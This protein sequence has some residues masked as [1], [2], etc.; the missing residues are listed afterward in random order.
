MVSRR[1]TV[2]ELRVLVT[3][4]DRVA[5]ILLGGALALQGQV[6]VSDTLGKPLHVAVEIPTKNH[7]LWPGVLTLASNE[8]RFESDRHGSDELLFS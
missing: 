7:Q 5:A 8:V 3:T 6:A 2:L 4:M 1:N